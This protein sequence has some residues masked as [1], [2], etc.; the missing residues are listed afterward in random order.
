VEEREG[1]QQGLLLSARHS[2]DS[3]AAWFNVE[4]TL[5]SAAVRSDDGR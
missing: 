2:N 1:R 3:A 4:Q 5:L